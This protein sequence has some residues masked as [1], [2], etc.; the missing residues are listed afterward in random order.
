MSQLH[1]M[2]KYVAA[3]SL[4][5]PGWQRKEFHNYSDANKTVEPDLFLKVKG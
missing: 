5:E 3:T 1:L 4:N 2:E